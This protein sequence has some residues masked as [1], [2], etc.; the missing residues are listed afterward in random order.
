MTSHA[1]HLPPS[2]EK[3]LYAAQQER[4]DAARH[5]QAQQREREGEDWRKHQR[6]RGGRER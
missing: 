5:Q 1:L 6:E 3:N 2:R 4:I